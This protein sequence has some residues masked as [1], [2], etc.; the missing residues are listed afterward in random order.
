MIYTLEG[1]L[2]HIPRMI[3]T[4][5]GNFNFRQIANMAQFFGLTLFHVKSINWI[6]AQ[7][8]SQS[9]IFPHQFFKF[10]IEIISKKISQ[11]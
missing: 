7:N 6:Q 11:T 5:L 1:I 2:V 4:D 9:D 3:F 8:I 10:S